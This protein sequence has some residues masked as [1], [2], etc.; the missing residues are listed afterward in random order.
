M[1]YTDI[2]GIKLLESSEL[3]VIWG[4]HNFIR[5]SNLESNICNSLTAFSSWKTKEKD[6][7]YW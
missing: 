6:N 7:Y 2:W 1:Q 4:L 5:K 3:G